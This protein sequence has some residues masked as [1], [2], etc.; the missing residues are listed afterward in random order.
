MF[1][2]WL[3]KTVGSFFLAFEQFFGDSQKQQKH[4]EIGFFKSSLF[5]IRDSFT[6]LQSCMVFI[7]YF[8]RFAPN[9]FLS[10]NL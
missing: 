7:S 8:C 1:F 2:A 4:L 9:Y 6:S 5:F 10:K 3:E